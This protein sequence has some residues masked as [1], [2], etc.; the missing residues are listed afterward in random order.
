MTEDT[1]SSYWEE[2]DKIVPGGNY[3][4]HFYEGDCFSCGYINP[5]YEYGHPS[6]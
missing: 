4:W 5:V 3:G 6:G 2:L 1:G